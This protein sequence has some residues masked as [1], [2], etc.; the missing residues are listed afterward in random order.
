MSRRL[1]A[2]TNTAALLVLGSAVAAAVLG[3]AARATAQTHPRGGPGPS[4]PVLVRPEQP[5][6]AP[7]GVFDERIEVSRVMVD[8]RVIDGR[9][10]PVAGL[11]AA[12]F[13]V[14]L[15]GRPAEVEAIEWRGAPV[16]ADGITGATQSA[17]APSYGVAGAP[18]PPAG[19]RV[20]PAAVPPSDLLVIFL[21]SADFIMEAKAVGH[22]RML[23]RLEELA[24][25]LAPGQRAAVLRHGGSLRLESD[26]TDD[27]AR[28][29]AALRRAVLGPGP[30]TGP[31][32]AAATPSPED[33][34]PSLAATLDPERARRASSPERALAVAADA[35]APLPGSKSIVFVGWGLT[36]SGRD[37]SRARAALAA[38]R[39]PVFVLDVTSA[40]GHLLE[41]GLR[42]LAHVSGGTYASTY[43][44]P[45]A[46]VHRLERALGGRYT[47]ILRVPRL[48]PGAH[49]LRVRLAPGA[50]SLGRWVLAPDAIQVADRGP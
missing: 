49:P 21:Q 8:V 28:L 23:P 47:L 3:S 42:H 48:L 25:R 44:F 4:E 12:D 11:G 38:A 31:G 30:E 1:L 2:T 36:G 46:A 41:G 20:P 18:A 50:A 17:A 27:P 7:Q 9:G 26:F 24:G 45:D 37:G 10:E 16:S 34:F 13:E 39:S 35:L 6:E 22:L 33:G 43:H 15:D 19:A 14:R 32:P 40:D 29:R 5:A